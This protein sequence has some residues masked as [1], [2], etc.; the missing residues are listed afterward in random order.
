MSASIR[1]FSDGVCA[2]SLRV[3]PMV[4]PAMDG[5]PP[6]MFLAAA[7]ALLLDVDGMTMRLFNAPHGRPRRSLRAGWKNEWTPTRGR[8]ADV[9]AL[10]LP[11]SC[12]WASKNA[13]EGI[14]DA[15]RGVRRMVGDCSSQGESSS[16]PRVREG[17]ARCAALRPSIWRNPLRCASFL[18]CRPRVS[19]RLVR[20]HFPRR[21][22]IK[23]S[24][25]RPRQQRQQQQRQ[26][27]QQQQQREQKP[28]RRR[29][30]TEEEVRRGRPM[31]LRK[32]ALAGWLAPSL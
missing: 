6:S 3:C 8:P 23:Q 9:Q 15:G 7:G 18:P 25:G 32:S 2:D 17:N 4:C 21:F 19:L 30:K 28:P 14:F 1:R 11:L 12:R 10:A 31:R 13:S 29:T 27:Q 5:P 24:T 20:Q 26:Q 22:H 16:G